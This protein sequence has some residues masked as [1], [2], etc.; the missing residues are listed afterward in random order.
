MLCRCGQSQTKPFCDKSHREHGFERVRARRA[1]LS[2][3]GARA[4]GPSTPACPAAQGEPFLPGP[5]LA[6]P[7]HLAGDAGDAPFGYNR[8]GNPTWAR[9]EAALG[10][11]EGGEA[12]LFA[13]GMAAVTRGALA[14]LRP[15]D[16]LVAP[17]DGYPGVRAIAREH[18]EPRGIEVRL[19]PD[20]R[21]G[22]C[23]RALDGATLVLR[24]DAVEP[25]A[26][27]ARRGRAREAAHAAGALR[28]RR[29]H[30][31]DAAAP[32]AARARRRRRR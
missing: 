22:A 20:R 19:V 8:D 2:A 11:L 28:R 6:G 18:L 30:A 26:G 31:G 25:G 27:R 10:E 16:V 24:R 4:R 17:D 7:F 21:R 32:A 14:A 29:Q 3:D 1:M 15:G 5:A 12:V 23:A 13:S 9:Y